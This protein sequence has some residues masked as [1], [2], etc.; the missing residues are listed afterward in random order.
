[1]GSSGGA[2]V[3]RR[4]GRRGRPGWCG[5][6]WVVAVDGVAWNDRRTELFADDGHVH[7]VAW[8][9]G[10][11]YMPGRAGHHGRGARAGHATPHTM[12]AAQAAV[13]AALWARAAERLVGR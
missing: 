13:E 8:P 4:S 9:D 5:V 12:A 3:R 1:M 10:N 2:L 7:G 11:W 6:T